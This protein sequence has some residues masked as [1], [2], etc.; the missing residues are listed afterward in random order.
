MYSKAHGAAIVWAALLLATLPA[1][2][3]ADVE[4]LTLSSFTLSE[5]Q[6]LTAT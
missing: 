3:R 1:V 6:V 2:A 4:T 5:L